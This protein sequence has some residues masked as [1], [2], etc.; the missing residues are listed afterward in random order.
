MANVTFKENRDGM[1]QLI[2]DTT[3]RLNPDLTPE[4]LEETIARAL[5][6]NGFKP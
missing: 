4:Q 3:K 5:E 1:R 2:I 6:H